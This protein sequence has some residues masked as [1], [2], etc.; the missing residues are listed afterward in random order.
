MDKTVLFHPL[1]RSSPPL[2]PTSISHPD[3]VKCLLLLP[4][5]FHPSFPLLLTGSTDEDIR[6]FDVS[7][8]LENPGNIGSDG[9]QEGEGEGVQE[10]KPVVAHYMEVTGLQP[11]LRDVDGKKEA[12]IV[13]SSLDCT[14]RRWS[15]RDIMDPPVLPELKKEEDEAEDEENPMTAEEEAELAELMG[16]D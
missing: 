7:S 16:D 15:M 8:I 4:S 13:S 5:S 10:K 6:V 11:W 12:W 9:A 14:L 3:Y 1:P 2:P